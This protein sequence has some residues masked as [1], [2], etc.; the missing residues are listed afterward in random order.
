MVQKLKQITPEW[1]QVHLPPVLIAVFGIATASVI[2]TNQFIRQTENR[3]LSLIETAYEE[4]HINL[5]GSIDLGNENDSTGT[6]INANISFE[7]TFYP[8]IE[9][10]SVAVR[11]TPFGSFET[12]RIYQS[13]T[14]GKLAGNTTDWISVSTNQFINFTYDRYFESIVPNFLANPHPSFWQE[15]FA[16]SN[17]ATLF[18]QEHLQ[19]GSIQVS[20]APEGIQLTIEPKTFRDI[21]IKYY[22]NKT[23][24]IIPVNE[25]AWY[26]N[27]SSFIPNEVFISS[28]G[29]IL[30]NISSQIIQNDKRV[31]EIGINLQVTPTKSIDFREPA[32]QIHISKVPED[33]PVTPAL[34]TLARLEE[35]Y[36]LTKLEEYGENLNSPDEDESEED[37]LADETNEEE[38]RDTEENQSDTNSSPQNAANLFETQRER[39]FNTKWRN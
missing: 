4:P 9:L 15:T 18:F 26:E 25:R 7:D 12:V 16:T 35:E 8:I 13:E 30:A 20:K 11:D 24:T 5:T 1:L 14:Y 37:L 23:G 22:E 27:V 33:T 3:F 17:E 21:S 28:N 29:Q 10:P 38:E 39:F 31:S 19:G 36:L 34:N 32:D 6:P 2:L